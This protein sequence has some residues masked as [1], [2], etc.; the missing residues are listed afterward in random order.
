[1]KLAE[2]SRED[3][4]A[5]AEE[6]RKDFAG[7][8]EGAR[9]DEDDRRV[10]AMVA[11]VSEVDSLITLAELDLRKAAADRLASTAGGLRG[12]HAPDRRTLGELITG[13]EDIMRWAT[14][15]SGASPTRSNGESVSVPGPDVSFEGTTLHELFRRPGESRRAWGTRAV[16]EFGASGPDTAYGSGIYDSSG[17][18]ALLP[19][20]QPI[21][22]VPRQAKLYLRDLLPAMTTTLAQVPYVQEVTPTAFELGASAVAEGGTKPTATLDFVGQ[23]ADPTVLAT[24][25]VLSKQMF[26]DAPAVVQYINMR[27]PY[28]VKFKEDWEF[29]NGSG[30]WP[31]ML[32]IKNQPNVQTGTVTT[33]DNAVTFGNMI[34]DI[35]NHDGA[36]TFVATNPLNAWAMFVKRAAAGS[37]TFDA[38]TPFSALPL[39]VWGVPTYRT[40]AMAQGSALAADGDRGFMIVDREQVNIQVYRERYAELNQI[41]VV[42]EERVGLAAFRPDLAVYTDSGLS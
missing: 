2:L 42:C 30:T 11:E 37:G 12:D 21:P 36:C 14:G 18:G 32:G 27:L 7:L 3:L 9:S 17:S 31:D 40:R 10:R 22:P 13:N 23:K 35:E 28:L 8:P 29:L 38:G 16:A 25:L 20:G 6:L 4:Y 39:T 34:A 24:T 5:R 33:G 1:M 41:L 19:V 15:S 26:E